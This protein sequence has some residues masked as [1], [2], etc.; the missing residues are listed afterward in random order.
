MAKDR[1]I[2]YIL[3]NPMFRE[4]VIKI[5]ITQNIEERLKQL[6][7]ETGVPCPFE[8]YVAYEIDNYKE[9]EKLMHCIY[10]GVE[11]HTDK[12]HSRKE[13]FQIHP[14]RVDEVLSRL[15]ELMNGKKVFVDNAKIY[16]P[17]QQQILEET[18]IEAEKNQIAKRFK[19][20]DYNIPTGT[21]LVFIKDDKTHCR[22]LDNNKVS[23]NGKEYSL[24]RLTFNLMQK[25]GYSGKHY[26]GYNYWLYNNIIL[27]DMQL[28]SENAE[29]N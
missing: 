17:E 12:E 9:I 3:T 6:G 19:F 22:V 2:V 11:R 13:F 14:S 4:D 23:F 18:S 7:C 25:L 29:N 24:S 26:N 15:A 28:P 16:T 10:R 5:G 8:C 21:E 20:Q 1:G 27:T